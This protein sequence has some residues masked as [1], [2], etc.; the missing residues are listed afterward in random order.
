MS[1]IIDQLLTV[2]QYLIPQHLASQLVKRLSHVR[3]P[4]VKNFL[5]KRFLAAYDVNL[6]E[7]LHSSSADYEHFNALFTRKLK[8]DARPLPNDET[9]VCSPADGRLSQFGSIETDKLI[10]AKGRLFRVDEF[11]AQP[12]DPDGRYR[13]GYFATIYLAPNDYHRVHVPFDGEIV[14][15]KF[16][17]GRLFSV[18]HRTAQT[19]DRLFSRNE[20]VLIEIQTIEFGRIMVVLVGALLVA[21]IGLEF[22]D[23][24]SV[25]YEPKNHHITDL[26]ITPDMRAVERGAGLGWFNM[27]STVILLFEKDRFEPNSELTIGQKIRM[28]A[29]LGHAR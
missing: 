10:Q 27:G 5:I 18:N 24:D 29:S 28:G 11:L 25:I 20:R 23:M 16:I 19:V 13:D 1:S 8:T 14:S 6:D 9:T 21:S 4:T 17:P 15:A 12:S 7:A 22:F 26:T 3:N 2:P